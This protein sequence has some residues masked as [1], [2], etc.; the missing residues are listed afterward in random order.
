[1]TRTKILLFMLIGAVGHNLSAM[2]ATAQFAIER[3]LYALERQNSIDFGS[4]VG[5]WAKNAILLGG[6][7]L[8]GKVVWHAFFAPPAALPQGAASTR[9]PTTH[10][11]QYSFK[12]I[13]GKVP[14]D[15]AEIT[16]FINNS[17]KYAA[18]GAR[19]PKGILLV[20]PPGT[21]KTSL[22]RAIAGELKIPFFSAS[23]SQFIEVYVG[24]GPKHVRELFDSA[25]EALK[26]LPRVRQMHIK[27]EG[28]QL[29]YDPEKLSYVS[30]CG[31]QRVSQ[32]KYDQQLKA[33]ISFCER[34]SY[35]GQ[36]D[37]FQEVEIRTLSKKALIFIDEIDAIGKG[38][39]DNSC[40]EYRA[41]LTELL[42][43]MAGVELDTSIFVIAAT[44]RIQ[45]IDPAL[46]R[47]GRFDRIAYIGLPD[48]ESRKA[49]IQ[50][51]AQKI[52]TNTSIDFAALAQQTAGMSGADLE[53]LVNEASIRAVREDAPLTSHKHFELVLGERRPH[54]IAAQAA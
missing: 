32:W 3:R 12:D 40:S 19:M 41:T 47:P 25:R 1:M 4:R 18:M 33:H 14:K 13:A 30:D 34:F 49:I 9:K 15:V 16:D 10:V 54:L 2:E 43:Q 46:T 26:Q 51:Y 6:C 31:K 50:H 20:G 24:T 11:G 23:A 8:M 48:A 22:A 44:N 27:P 37:T 45:D 38:R 28:I 39:D 7:A 36:T 17:E 21:G 5:I 42:H 53:N 35:V 29:R 52:K